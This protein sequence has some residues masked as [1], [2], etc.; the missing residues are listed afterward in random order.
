MRIGVAARAIESLPVID[1]S[2]FRLELNRFFVAIGAWHGH[3][4]ARQHKAAFFMFSQGECGRLISLKIVATIA[5]IEIG[6][7]GELRG[8]LVRVAIGAAVELHFEKR[9]LGFWNMT[10]RALQTSMSTLQ[11]IRAR[12]VL[13]YRECRRLPALHRMAGSAFP[14]VRTLGKLAVVRI[15][16]V[17][18]HALGKCEWFLEVSAGMALGT[19]HD[20]VLAFQRKFRLGVIEAFV[21]RLQRNLFPPV[22]VVARLATLSE[23]PMVRVFVAIGTLVERNACVLGLAVGSVDVTLCT[24]HLLMQSGQRVLSLGVVELGLARLADIDCLPVFEVVALLAAWSEAALVAILVADNATRRQTKIGS[25]EIPGFDGAT[26]LR[27]DMGRVMAFATRQ[28]CMFAL[29]RIS[30]FLVIERLD[31][32]FDQRKIFS[33]VFGVAAGAFLAGT[34]RDLVRGVQTS[35]CGKSSRNLGMTFQTLQRGL[36]TE[37]VATGAVG[38][39]V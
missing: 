28:T 6:C 18:V 21:H 23:A 39:S 36:S 8:V 35:A 37:L 4:P 15:G 5:S 22:R 20:G 38:G 32:P 34:G 3:M 1:H 11:R 27:R 9:V 30:R 25:A 29:D 2:R 24:L 31:V 10:L 16:F 14:G 7:C 19:I 17:A 12:G 13:L 26:F 33:V